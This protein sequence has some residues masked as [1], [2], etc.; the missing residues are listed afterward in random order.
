MTLTKNNRDNLNKKNISTNISLNIG[1]PSSLATKIIDSTLKILIQNLS[2]K[3]QIKI[4]NFGIFVPKK[5]KIKS[6]DESKK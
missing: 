5:K 3:G 4:K 1:I 2:L 6:R